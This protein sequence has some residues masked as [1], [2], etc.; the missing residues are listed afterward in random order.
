MFIP[1]PMKTHYTEAKAY[2]PINLSSLTLQTI[3]KP[4]DRHMRDKKLRFYLLNSNH[5]AY[6]PGKPTDTA[7]P[8]VV[9]HIQNVMKHWE[10]ALE[11]S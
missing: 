3:A 4:V 9:T 10:I 7:L 8:N 1:Q 11:L 2:C 6:Q 5:T